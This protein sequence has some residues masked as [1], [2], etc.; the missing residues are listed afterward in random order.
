MLYQLS[1]ASGILRKYSKVFP[2]VEMA[3]L[4]G[5]AVNRILLPAIALS[6]PAIP[7]EPPDPD[8]PSHPRH[9]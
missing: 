4:I 7:Q 8:A 2:R 5:S 6:L 3:L 1:Y 9:R